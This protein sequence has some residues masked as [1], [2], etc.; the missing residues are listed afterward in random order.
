MNKRLLAVKFGFKHFGGAL[1]D[2]NIEDNAGWHHKGGESR[3]EQRRGE[4]RVI[5]S[6]ASTEGRKNQRS[7]M[8][9][10]NG[11]NSFHGQEKTDEPGER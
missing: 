7:Y 6:F 8:Y 2:R 3:A 5:R 11:L 9:Q 4:N 10:L 1:G